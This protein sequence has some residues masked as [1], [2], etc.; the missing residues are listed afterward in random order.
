MTE[1]FITFYVNYY[2]GSRKYDPHLNISIFRPDGMKKLARRA[3]TRAL[4]SMRKVAVSNTVRE[5]FVS[6]AKV[7]SSITLSAGDKGTFQV[8]GARLGLHNFRFTPGRHGRK[9]RKGTP[10]KAAVRRDKGLTPI[11]RAFRVKKWGNSLWQRLYDGEVESVPHGFPIKFLS[12][13]AVPQM[14]GNNPD[15]IGAMKDAAEEMFSKVLK[16][17]ISRALGGAG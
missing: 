12:T 7:R 2:E 1:P 16:H 17:E 5:Y 3:M 11:P 6:A 15:T 13:L 14:I 8:R 10:L 4:Q 9:G